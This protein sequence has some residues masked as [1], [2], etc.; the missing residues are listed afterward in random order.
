[1]AH[2]AAKYL[3]LLA[4]PALLGQATLV[5]EEKTV[6]VDSVSETWR[7]VWKKAPKPAC[8]PDDASSFTCPCNGFA[9]GESGKLDLVR[10]RDGREIDRLA[11][12][13]QT[14]QHWPSS[15]HDL[16]SDA[17]QLADRVHARPVVEAMDLA[18]YDHD[19]QSTEF[20]LQTESLPCGK[21]AGFVLGLSSGN[22]RLHIFGS[23]LHP[24][25]ALV[26]QKQQWEA[27]RSSAG[28]LRVLDWKCGDHASQTE[29]ELELEATGTAIRVVKREYGCDA[30]DHRTKLLTREIR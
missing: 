25:Q 12:G 22:R 4:S 29:T 11:L 26:L 10:F 23:A 16:K 7:L 15:N 17:R 14:V 13:E 9:Y 24:R 8:S 19:G 27:L 20:F 3:L 2:R 21:R 28:P 5:R 18:D 6:V 1:M 30:H